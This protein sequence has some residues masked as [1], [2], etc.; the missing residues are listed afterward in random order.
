MKDSHNFNI[1]LKEVNMKTKLKIGLLID[2]T[3]LPD[4]VFTMLDQISKGPYANISLIVKNDAPLRS[5]KSRYKKIL[6]DFNHLLYLMLAKLETIL[7]RPVPDA[8]KPKDILELFPNVPQIDAKPIQKGESNYFTHYD[9]KKVKSYK[10]DVII[11]LCFRIIRGEI[12]KCAVC[13]VWSYHHGDNQTHRGGPPCFWEVLKGFPETG[14]VMQI[15][16]EDL[17]GGKVLYRSY[18]KTHYLS[19]NRNKNAVYWKTL[20]FL[21]RKL[22]ELYEVGS[23]EFLARVEQNNQHPTFYSRA[24]YTAPTNTQLL[25]I[26]LRHYSK[27]ILQKKL[28]SL[29]YFDQWILLYKFNSNSLFSSSFQSFKKIIPPKDRFWADPFIIYHND[30]YYIFVEE[31]LYKQNKGYISYFTINDKGSVS[32]PKKIIEQPYHLSYPFVFSYNNEYYM[33][34]ETADNQTIELYISIDFPEKWKLRCILMENIFAVDSTLLYNDGI[35]WLFTNVREQIGA[36]ECDELFLFYSSDLFSGYWKPHPLN[37]IVS[38]VKSSRPAGKI[39]SYSGNLYRPSQN[40]SK[41]YGYGMQINQIVQLT[42]TNYKE[43]CINTIEPLWEKK[44]IATHTLNRAKC[45]TVIDGMM[46]RSKYFDLCG[47]HQ[48]YGRQRF[49]T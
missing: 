11:N 39:F 2:A 1:F 15:L 14:S 30:S 49:F 10:L 36:S 40:C 47:C 16:T 42:K 32:P 43:K 46:K 29:L 24:I 6:D 21:P 5:S 37:P 19:C 12:L 7:I 17:N 13:G 9:I 22:K 33:I 28:R 44:I 48:M 4:W 41:M 38:D 31:F 23:T 3:L 18:S 45:L 35:W 27:S 20:A 34:P 26:A 8:F 25:G